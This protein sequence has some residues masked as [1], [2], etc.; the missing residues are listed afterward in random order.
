M[1]VPGL[2]LRVAQGLRLGIRLR[3]PGQTQSPPT[4][5]LLL[6]ER[7][8]ERVR[9]PELLPLLVNPGRELAEA[10]A[11]VEVLAEGEVPRE[12][13]VEYDAH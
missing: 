9:R 7:S 12:H 2:A 10:E 13:G 1:S 11:V 3:L 5:P 4:Q 8:P 6:S